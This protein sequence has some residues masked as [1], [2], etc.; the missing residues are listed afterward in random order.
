MSLKQSRELW[1]GL[2]V[3]CLAVF[4]SGST[5][6]SDQGNTVRGSEHV[7]I[8]ICF[9]GDKR[10]LTYRRLSKP[11]RKVKRFRAGN[12][13]LFLLIFQQLSLKYPLPAQR[14]IETKHRERQH[15][16]DHEGGAPRIPCGG[17]NREWKRTQQIV[18]PV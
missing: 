4:G 7:V 8:A 18:S 9:L 11:H 15:G 1:R 5:D 3:E 14:R 13:Q 12:S 10:Q 17:I 2:D 16:G 6:Y